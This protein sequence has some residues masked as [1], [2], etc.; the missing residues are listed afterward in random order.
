MSWADSMPG[1]QTTLLHFYSVM[2]VVIRIHAFVVTRRA[3]R[4]GA[5]VVALNRG[6]AGLKA[7]NL[8]LH[9]SKVN[10]SQP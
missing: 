8:N 9:M 1:D 5:Q 4:C 6:W 7:S 3:D 10:V 2:M